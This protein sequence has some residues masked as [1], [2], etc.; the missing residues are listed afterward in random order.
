MPNPEVTESNHQS[1][2]ITL[3]QTRRFSRPGFDGYDYGDGMMLI[4]VHGEHPLK[5]I[6]KGERTYTVVSIEG[7]GEF[8]LNGETFPI[9]KGD[10][11]IVSVGSEY[12]YKG[13]KMTLIE[14]NKPET[15]STTLE[16]IK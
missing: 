10:K 14:E 16:E 1:T 13:E 2:R 3:E 8:T 4:D 7:T 9:C 15:T 12:R 6:D 11:F 5:R